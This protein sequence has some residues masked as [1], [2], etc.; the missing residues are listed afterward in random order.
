LGAFLKHR[1][2]YTTPFSKKQEL[3]EK[4]LKNTGKKCL[5]LVRLIAPL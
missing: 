4:N 3:F 2:Y 5:G 1:Q